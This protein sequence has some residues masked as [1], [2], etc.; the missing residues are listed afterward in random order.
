MQNESSSHAK[1]CL[2]IKLNN[3][4]KFYHAWF[5]VKTTFIRP[6][7][8]TKTRPEMFVMKGFSTRVKIDDVIRLFGIF[9]F[10]RKKSSIRLDP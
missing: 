5:L 7:D 8:R 6:E 2:Q 9:R 3:I 10:K 4:S 1:Y